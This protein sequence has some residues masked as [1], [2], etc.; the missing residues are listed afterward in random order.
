MSEAAELTAQA[1][2]NAGAPTARHAEAQHAQIVRPRRQRNKQRGQQK[3]T[4]LGSAQV[5]DHGSMG[6]LRCIGTLS[7]G[8]H[9]FRKPKVGA[10]GTAIVQTVSPTFGEG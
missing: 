9:D 6:R 10:G 2:A 3:T 7:P 8:A 1:E 4:Q 5:K